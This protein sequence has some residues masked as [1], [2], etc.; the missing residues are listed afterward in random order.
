MDL[1]LCYYGPRGRLILKVMFSLFLY[2]LRHTSWILWVSSG[3]CLGVHMIFSDVWCRYGK[4]KVRNS[5]WNAVPCFWCVVWRERNSIC[6]E[7][8]DKSWQMIRLN[9]L[10]VFHS[11]CKLKYD[12]ETENLLEFIESLLS[13]AEV[14]FFFSSHVQNLQ[15]SF[16][17][18]CWIQLQ[19]SPVQKQI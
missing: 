17:L 5:W 12:N 8:K 14:L 19:S 15:H 13:L 11:W 10:L 16:V 9:C 4:D 2:G 1:S 6:F 18:F 7:E 3:P